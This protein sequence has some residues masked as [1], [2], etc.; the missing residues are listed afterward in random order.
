MWPQKKYPA[1]E[2]LSGAGAAGPK[3]RKKTSPCRKPTQKTQH[4]LNTL[5]KTYPSLIHR[6]EDPSRFSDAIPYLIT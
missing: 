2:Q 1:E 4:Y 3:L 5:P 6:R